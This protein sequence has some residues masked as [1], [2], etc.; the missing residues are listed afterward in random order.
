MAH[1]LSFIQIW[2]DERFSLGD[3][4][5]VTIK[6]MLKPVV[7]EVKNF[8]QSDVGSSPGD[9]IFLLRRPEISYIVKNFRRIWKHIWEL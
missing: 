5:F 4:I 6:L 9:I 3:C 1:K 8:L 2:R 7:C